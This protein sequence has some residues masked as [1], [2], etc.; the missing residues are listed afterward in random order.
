MPQPHD[1]PRSE[2]EPAAAMI[3]AATA[4]LVVATVGYG[5]LPSGPVGAVPR[6]QPCQSQFFVFTD[7]DD[8]GESATRGNVTVVRK[9]GVLGQYESGRLAGYSIDGEQDLLVNNG[10]NMAQIHGGLTATSPDGT[11]SISLRYNGRADLDAGS[12]TGTFVAGDGTGEFSGYRATG[13]IEATLVGP[14]AFRGVDI[15]L[16]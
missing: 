15:G 10:T 3:R 14:A 7:P 13:T 11:S 5:L 2:T 9:S 12:A 16:C 8:P 4:A 6:N 1:R